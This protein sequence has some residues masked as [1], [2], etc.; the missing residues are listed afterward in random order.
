MKRFFL[1]LFFL[2]FLFITW[3]FIE[4][5][6]KNTS[7]YPV[8]ENIKVEINSL[9][10]VEKQELNIVEKPKLSI[11]TEQVFSIHNIVLGEKKK[12][13][14]KSLESQCAQH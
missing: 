1:S 9:K 11:P 5:Q 14:N 2:L 7:F 6:L 3:P 10:S 8:I 12:L 13:L 4:K